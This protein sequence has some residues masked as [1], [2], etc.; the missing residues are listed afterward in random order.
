LRGGASVKTV[1]D[2]LGY[3]NASALSRLFTQK[4]GASP[5]EWLARQA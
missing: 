1:A 2:E 3:A 5:R 4:L